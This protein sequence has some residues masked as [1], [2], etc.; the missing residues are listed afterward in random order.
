M[1]L[2]QRTTSTSL[3]AAASV[4]AIAL[5]AAPGMSIDQANELMTKTIIPVAK[6]VLGTSAS[7]PIE[8]AASNARLDEAKPVIEDVFSDL[9]VYPYLAP[10]SA[11]PRKRDWN[12]ESVELGSIPDGMAPFPGAEIVVEGR[13]HKVQLYGM[14]ANDALLALPDVAGKFALTHELA[15]VLHRLG[16]LPGVVTGTAVADWEIVADVVS[17]FI[18]R[19]AGVDLSSLY[20]DTLA[21]SSQATL[22]AKAATYSKKARLA[23]A[24]LMIF[25]EEWSAAHAPAAQRAALVKWASE[26]WEAHK[27]EADRNAAL[28]A[29]VAAALDRY[30]GWK[31]E[32][33][34]F[35][36]AVAEKKLAWD[37]L[38]VEQ[39]RSIVDQ[40][41]ALITE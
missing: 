11:I 17:T 19:Q 8:D 20:S 41:K 26:E 9:S 35:D 40:A 28:R 31:L 6:T 12:V 18:L 22:A 39:R 24:K 4:A 23:A 7:S 30:K 5:C 38:T 1:S 21:S 32:S 16:K 27:S 3:I 36:L 10:T 29:E 25:D 33:D 14:T 37:K 2:L 34:E 15:H 13:A